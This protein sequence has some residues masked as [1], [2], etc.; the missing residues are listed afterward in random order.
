MERDLLGRAVAEMPVPLSWR[1]VQSPRGNQPVDRYAITQADMHLLLM[2]GDIR[3]PIGLEWLIARRAGRL[4]VL[5]L[6]ENVSRTLAALDFVRTVEN[7]TPWRTFKE[8]R[9]LRRRVEIL[10]AN[11][12]LDRAVTFSLTKDEVDL[13]RSWLAER[14]A[15]TVSEE[16]IERG[17]AGDSGL[18]L[19]AERFEPSD[20]ILLE[21]ATQNNGEPGDEPDISECSN[22]S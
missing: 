4:P 16:R 8:S 19:S 3:A 18:I 21:T 22:Q 17:G 2:G 14:E 10:L 6:K 5:F 11:H 1:V 9:E 20:G 7:Q 13:L 15:G 12:L